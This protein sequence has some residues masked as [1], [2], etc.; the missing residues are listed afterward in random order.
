MGS[1][2]REMYGKFYKR[3]VWE[4]LWERCM[5]NFIREMYGKFHKRLRD[6]W[7]ISFDRETRIFNEDIKASTY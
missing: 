1:F 4:I 2:I 7:E 5:G 3:D 6:A